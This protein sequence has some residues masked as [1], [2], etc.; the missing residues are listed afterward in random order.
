MHY[1]IKINRVWRKYTNLAT[2]KITVGGL[3]GL[4]PTSSTGVQGY[5]NKKK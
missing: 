3:R 5:L 2:F 1:Y 4:N